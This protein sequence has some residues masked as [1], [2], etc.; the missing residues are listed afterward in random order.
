MK[1]KHFYTKGFFSGWHEV[2]EEKYN[3]FVKWFISHSQ[4]GEENVKRYTKIVEY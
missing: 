3:N 4:K 2:D 1:T